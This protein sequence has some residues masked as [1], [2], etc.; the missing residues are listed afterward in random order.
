MKLILNIMPANG[1]YAIFSIR[2]KGKKDTYLATPLVAWALVKDEDEYTLV[3]GMSAGGRCEGV[4]LVEISANFVMYGRNEDF[5]RM[6]EEGETVEV[7]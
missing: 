1:W 3:E 2:E 6:R 4:D 5:I 7:L